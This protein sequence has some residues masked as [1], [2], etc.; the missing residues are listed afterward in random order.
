MQRI[1]NKSK[2]MDGN[3]IYIYQSHQIWKT[4]R[5]ILWISILLI[6]LIAARFMFSKQATE[7]ASI[8]RKPAST[9]K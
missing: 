5:A 6:S 7:T 3:K 9:V 1:K 4:R 2:H 8:L